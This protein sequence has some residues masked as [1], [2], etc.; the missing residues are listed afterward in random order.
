MKK[1]KR[2][3]NKELIGALIGYAGSSYTDLANRMD[4]PV[5]RPMISQIMLDETCN[6]R[7][8]NQVT[9]I[10]RP[11]AADLAVKIHNL[12]GQDLLDAIFPRVHPESVAP[13]ETEKDSPDFPERKEKL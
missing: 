12:F 11:A 7:L 13:T 10:L 3:V 4:P 6:E 2:N 8:M 5:S 9:E 1:Q